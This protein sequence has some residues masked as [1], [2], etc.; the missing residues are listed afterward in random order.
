MYTEAAVSAGGE[1]QGGCSSPPAG[2]SIAA[3]AIQANAP[4]KEKEALGVFAMPTALHLTK[5]SC[6][7]LIAVNINN[8]K[9]THSS[10]YMSLV[11]FFYLAWH[12]HRPHA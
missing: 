10:T 4:I 8:H 2:G 3:A 5:E 11:H 6:S 1:K 7:F 12:Y 9:H